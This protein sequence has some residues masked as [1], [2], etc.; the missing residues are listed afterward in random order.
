M[1]N[2]I[3]QGLAGVFYFLFR[4]NVRCGLNLRIEVMCGQTTLP[5]GRYLFDSRDQRALVEYEFDGIDVRWSV[6]RTLRSVCVCSSQPS[7]SRNRLVNERLMLADS[8]LEINS[9]LGNVT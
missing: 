3:A 8:V 2:E 5:R 9:H 6:D 7:F 1:Q 4:D